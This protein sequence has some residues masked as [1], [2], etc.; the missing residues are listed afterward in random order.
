ME[1]SIRR[2]FHVEMGVIP[3]RAGFDY[4]RAE[5]TEKWGK[6]SEWEMYL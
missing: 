5:I 6:M 3:E 4:G 2:A 1:P